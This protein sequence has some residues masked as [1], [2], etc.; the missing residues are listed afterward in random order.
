MTDQ[1]PAVEVTT[2]LGN[3][4]VEVYPDKAPLSAGNFLEYVDK[5][6]L[7]EGSLYRITTLTNEPHKPFPIEVIQFGWKWLEGAK[8]API[9]PIAH[10]STVLT[11]LTHKKGTISTARFE[12]D[13]GGYAF[14]ICMR[15]E[16]DLDHGGRRHPDGQ[17]FAAFGR[18]LS[19]W[20][21][22]ESIFARA[23]AQDIMEH[24][25]P[26]IAARRL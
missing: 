4:V 2:D 16:P 19:G 21:V 15:D 24:P 3:F 10:E 17:G 20:D 18:I 12:L 8:G 11:G 23:E 26:I 9:P 25:V 7:G 13:N 5:G 1:T 6:Y 14:F 22:V